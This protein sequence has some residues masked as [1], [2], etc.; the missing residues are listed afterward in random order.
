MYDNHFLISFI[1]LGIMISL[2][3]C[4]LAIQNRI[5]CWT[6]SH[7][8][9]SSNSSNSKYST[10]FNTQGYHKILPNLYLGNI[11]SAENKRFI[12]FVIPNIK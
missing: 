2:Y 12:R 11:N 6:N 10:F 4:I 8:S 5:G 7:P 9:N 3:L 1:I